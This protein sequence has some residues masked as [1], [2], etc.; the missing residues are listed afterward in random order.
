MITQET[1]LIL[2]AGAS[3]AY[4]FP[5]GQKLKALIWK[6]L[7]K[8][9]DE[10]LLA[11]GADIRTPTRR[12]DSENFVEKFRKDLLLSPDYSIDSFLE[13]HND[14]Y[15]KLGKVGIAAVLLPLE[16]RRYLFDDWMLSLTE[17][18]FSSHILLKDGHWYQYLFN[19][20]CKDCKK[21]GDFSENKN[22]S[23][24]T[25]NYDRSLEYYLF[26]CLHA[27]YKENFVE[28][29]EMLKNIPIIHVYG[30][31]G[32][33]PELS[34]PDS[35]EYDM[36]EDVPIDSL[37]ITERSI[38]IINDPNANTSPEFQDAQKL[39]KEAKRIYFLGFGYL[40][41]NMRRLFTNYTATHL[42]EFDILKQVGNRC[43]GTTLGISPHH[44]NAISMKGL[45]NLKLDFRNKS[46]HP[47]PILCF[48]ATN[49][50]E[51]LFYNPNAVL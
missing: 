4:G 43:F 47:N 51:F 8:C 39:I 37:K 11:I 21:F 22:V 28:C 9:D 2:G 46:S 3:M 41:E 17:E 25:F 15:K 35:I 50:Y 32:N 31:L 48:P 38:K 6:K 30:K 44:L 26:N 5:S 24:V 20:M 12:E 13:H 34:D 40:E 45:D 1:V 33:L 36:P 7:G 29:A 16:K 49:I 14:E 19:Q 27:K 23:I 18:N 10:I 42:S